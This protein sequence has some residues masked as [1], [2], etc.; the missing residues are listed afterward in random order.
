MGGNLLQCDDW[1]KSLLTNTELIA[2]DQ[3][4][5]SNHAVETTAQSAVWTAVP[6][7]GPG[8]YVAV[9]NRSDSAQ[10]FH[11]DFSQ[12]GIPPSEYQLR[13]LW[14]HQEVGRAKAIDVNLAAHASVLYLV[15]PAGQ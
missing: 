13:D 7:S 12:L 10:S 2:V 1:T 14:E 3:R 6:E 15:R 4:S 8:Y 11:R 9:F 5:K